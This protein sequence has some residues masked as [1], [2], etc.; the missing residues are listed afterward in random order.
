MP[1]GSNQISEPYEIYHVG[2]LNMHYDTVN[3]SVK[4]WKLGAGQLLY[5]HP[6]ERGT[7]RETREE[8]NRSIVVKRLHYYHTTIKYLLNDGRFGEL[9]RSIVVLVVAQCAPLSVEFSNIANRITSV[10]PVKLVKKLRG[11][12]FGVELWVTVLVKYIPSRVIY[13][14]FYK[15]QYD[16]QLVNNLLNFTARGW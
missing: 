7:N 15:G 9:N 8:L 14:S 3:P 6:Y 4:S 1:W 13:S 2:W 11:G 10:K 5:Y 16:M 12:C